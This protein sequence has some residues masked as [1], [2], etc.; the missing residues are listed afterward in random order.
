[1][2]D[3]LSEIALL[4]IAVGDQLGRRRERY[5]RRATVEPERA[6]LVGVDRP[7]GGGGSD[8]VDISAEDSIQELRALSET[9]GLR[10]VGHTVQLLRNGINPAFYIGTGKVQD[11]KQ[12]RE[13]NDTGVVVFD[14]A[15]SPAQQR[16]LEKALCCKVI[17]RSQLILD[18]FAQRARSQAGKLQVELAQL[19]YLRPRLTRQWSHLSRLGGGVGTRGPGESQLEVDRR[20]VRERISTLKRKLAEVE[21]TRSLHRRER[22]RV[23]FPTV[24]LVG[25][26]NAGKS[27]LMNRLTRADVLVEDKPFATLDPTSRRLVLPNGLVAMVID[28]V[29][30]IN[31]LPHQLIDS[32][33]STLE[34]V[35]RA[36]LLVHVLDS[37]DKHRVEHK[38]VT[39]TV[40][41]EIG[42]NSQNRI[43]VLNKVDKPSVGKASTEGPWTCPRDE[44]TFIDFLPSEQLGGEGAYFEVSAKYGLGMEPLLAEISRLLAA[45]QKLVELE[46]PIGNTN[47]IAWLRDKGTVIEET[48]TDT[49]VRISTMLSVK[50][51]GQLK[52][53]LAVE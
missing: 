38:T 25:Y 40:L 8:R 23:P 34:E 52:K 42:A 37:T 29:G 1:M 32:F 11:V 22:Q 39:E 47:L 13:E 46:L 19:E 2:W 6:L 49:C 35:T 3:P 24:A 33:K 36:D 53:R 28:T 31:R 18:I 14:D 20:R 51:A 45:D 17:D 10:I 41:E 7:R 48:Y 9:A 15:L 5:D 50:T 43:T 4:A 30:F 27:T 16:N 44:E 26:T 21:R 12:L